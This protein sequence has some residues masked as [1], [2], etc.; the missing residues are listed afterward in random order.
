MDAYPHPDPQ[1]NVSRSPSY[2]HP[3]KEVVR[4]WMERRAHA[5]RPP[6]PPAEIRREL[7]WD[8]ASQVP[9]CR[10][11]HAALLL[12]ATLASLATWTMVAWCW[13]AICPGSLPGLS[14]KNE[15]GIS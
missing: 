7:G 8:L 2:P 5:R 4:A 13:T 11:T 12:P 9:A 1:R 14:N 6:P 15:Q 3:S 10:L